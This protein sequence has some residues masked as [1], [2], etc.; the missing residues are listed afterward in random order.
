MTTKAAPKPAGRLTPDDVEDLGSTPDGTRFVRWQGN[1]YAMSPNTLSGAPSPVLD[2]NEIRIGTPRSKVEYGTTTTYVDLRRGWRVPT[3]TAERVLR[4]APRRPS[5]PKP[6]A[7]VDLL[8]RAPRFAPRPD[9]VLPVP[10]HSRD[11][12]ADAMRAVS[13]G[14]V[15]GFVPG[16]RP[17]ADIRSFM[18]AMKRAGVEFS[19]TPGG[20]LRVRAPGARLVDA[21]V[22]LIERLERGII[23]ILSKHPLT[24]E[25]WHADKAPEASTVGLCNVWLCPGHASGEI[26]IAVP[27]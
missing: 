17:T 12:E 21:D 16:V 25:E 27:S 8:A 13:G 23:G 2:D 20:K 10:E 5:G 1:E 19:L 24:C 26:V 9:R 11:P 22:E 7:P 18:A 6:L 15:P 3:G 14:P 4:A